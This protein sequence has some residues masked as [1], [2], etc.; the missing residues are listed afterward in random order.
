MS[1]I[2]SPPAA[3]SGTVPDELQ[4]R[5]D[6]F[7]AAAAGRPAFARGAFLAVSLF[8]TLHGAIVALALLDSLRWRG[9]LVVEVLLVSFGGAYLW[10][11]LT[12][13]V[14][15]LIQSLRSTTVRGSRELI[16]VAVFGLGLAVLISVVIAG[17]D[18]FLNGQLGF[19]PV[20][21]TRLPRDVLASFLVLSAGVAHDYLEAMRQ[22]QQEAAEL[23]AKLV[24]TRLDG[25]RAQLNPHFLFNTLNA[26]AALATVDPERVQRIIA[27]L[28][29]LL[30][31]MLAGSTA[32]EISLDEEIAVLRRYLDIL[33][34]RYGEWLSTRIERD[35]SLGTALV[36]NLILQPLADNAVKHAIGPAGEGSIIVRASREGDTILLS[37]EDSGPGEQ[38]G[39]R[40]QEEMAHVGGF[41]LRHTQER[42]KQLYG[43]AGSVQL[44]PTTTGGMQAVV[45]VPYHTSPI[46]AG[47][48][49][50]TNTA[51]SDA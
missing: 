21:R 28:S 8:W 16:A 18:H 2:D 5:R 51:S 49:V 22:R 11:I 7:L 19:R 24:Q 45:R 35:P 48:A 41:G 32:A 44:F 1:V 25:L 30:R 37:V 46:L 9:D 12:R 15:R 6:E 39:E 33:E 34:L 26:I 17:G 31:Y 13:P 43:K 14:F 42:L 40:R 3:G 23:R 4:S 50:G 27:Q 29:D 38:G 20:L 36:P 47:V 10:A